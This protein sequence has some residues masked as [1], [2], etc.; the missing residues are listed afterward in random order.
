M[1]TTPVLQKHHEYTCK[2]CKRALYQRV[3]RGAMVKIFLFWLPLR[4]YLCTNCLTSQ[5]VWVRNDDLRGN[6]IAA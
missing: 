6:E 4:K 3:H 1:N 2:R 5:Y